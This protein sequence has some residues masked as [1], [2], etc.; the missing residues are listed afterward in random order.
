[1][2]TVNNDIEIKQILNA[3]RPLPEDPKAERVV[4]WKVFR[5]TED[6]LEYSHHIL[7]EPDQTVV[8]GHASDSVGEFFWL[9]I[10]VADL[11]AWGNTQS[12]QLTDPFDS[13]DP[14]GQGQG[15]GT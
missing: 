14:K 4:L 9:G 11:E 8:G 3:S 12:I 10:E 5:N 1:M 7:L 15:P 13:N 2:Q 6:A